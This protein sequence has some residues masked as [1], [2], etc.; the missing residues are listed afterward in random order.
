MKEPILRVESLNKHYGKLHAINGVSFD[1]RPGEI[2]GLLGHNGAGKS[3][4][5]KCLMDVVRSYSGT[6]TVA[7]KD[8]RQK[9]WTV[10]KN[11]GFL[12]EPA[13]C[14]YL[15]ARE[16]LRLLD[17]VSGDPDPDRVDEVLEIVSLKKFANKLVSGFSFG[18]R[19][20]LG[21]AQVLLTQPKLIV[22]DEPTVGL[23]P[24]GVEIIKDIIVQCS[25]QG[26]AVLF[27][28]HQLSDVLD[29]CH[30]TIV[31]N[32]GRVV[33]DGPAEKLN[34]KY[35]TVQLARPVEE[36][37]EAL[38]KLSPDLT[39]EESS[40]HFTSSAIVQ[41]VLNYLV[42]HQLPIVDLDIDTSMDKLKR[43]MQQ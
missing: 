2:V 41:V 5:I 36:H 15:S 28:S 12:L 25:Q 42:Q 23:D 17:T 19:Q 33:F 24:V 10:R 32:Q 40:I 1:I 37:T 31:M 29:I 43:L 3:T 6:I 14:D 4:L 8:I 16:N 35:Y 38:K 21:L 27:S 30:R 26:V 7:G 39:V 9:H 13:F 34:R 18:M 22:L 11:V 20:R